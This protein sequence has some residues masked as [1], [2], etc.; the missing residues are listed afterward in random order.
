MVVSPTAGTGET[1]LIRYE[2][3]RQ[4]LVQPEHDGKALCLI[5]WTVD[6]D[7]QNAVD[8]LDF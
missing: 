1:Y 4:F 5:E 6:L 2:V 3:V 8:F 7:L